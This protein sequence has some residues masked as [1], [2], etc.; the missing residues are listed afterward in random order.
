M[1]DDVRRGRVADLEPGMV[2]SMPDSGLDQPSIVIEI[3]NEIGT[4][5]MIVVQDLEAV[6]PSD[7]RHMLGVEREVVIHVVQVE[8]QNYKNISGRTIDVQL[9][10]GAHSSVEPGSTFH[11]TGTP[12]PEVFEDSAWEHWTEPIQIDQRWT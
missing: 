9:G 12:R 4:S 8:H 11:Y 6:E 2:F 1:T 7:V 10:R 3:S 5:R